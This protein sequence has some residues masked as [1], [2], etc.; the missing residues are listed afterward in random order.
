MENLNPFKLVQLQFDKAA[1][2][3]GLPE[4]QRMFLKTPSRNVS[5]DFPVQMDD[6]SV[7]MFTGYRVQHNNTRGPYKGGIRFAPQ[8]DLDEVK[9]LASLMTW[10]TALVDVPFGGAKGGVACDPRAMSAG[11]LERLT[12]RFTYE[13]GDVIGPETDIPAPDMGTNAMVMAWMLDTYSMGQ[14]R[15]CFAVVT[16]KPLSVGGSLGRAEATGRGVTQCVVDT[17]ASRGEDPSKMTA[18]VQGLGNVGGT[19]MRLLA[20]KGVRIIGASDMSAAV[21]DPAGIDVAALTA[22]LAAP[23]RLLKDLPGGKFLERKEDLLTMPCDVLVPAAMENAITGANAGAVRARYVVEGANAPTTLDAD[24]ILEKNGIV[25]VP[26]ILANAGGVIVSYYEWAQN[27]Q[28]EQWCEDKVNAKLAEKLSVALGSVLDLSRERS[29]S[30]RMAA[31]MI[32]IGRVAEASSLRGYF[33]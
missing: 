31:F 1:D 27:V 33:P 32:A 25:V 11:E 20:Q 8:V 9:A 28:R 19:T 23:G 12:R 4:R 29:V 21:Y 13:I 30:L 3:I 15:D 18:V 6:G 7:R 5:V 24:A 10:K 17:L 14:R 16:G 22:F 2:A 26:D